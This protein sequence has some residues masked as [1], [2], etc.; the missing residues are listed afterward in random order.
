MKKNII[1]EGSRG[2]F[3]PLLFETEFKNILSFG[4]KFEYEFTV[5]SGNAKGADKMG[6]EMAK[7]YNLPFEVFKPDWI[8][9][10]RSA[11]VIRNVEM[12][13]SADFCIC[14]WDGKSPGTNHM[15]NICK[16]KNIVLKTIRY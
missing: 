5:L 15:R 14:F 2:F 8:K 7:K 13:N 4:K 10:G 3:D 1:I 9:N 16:R 12:A 11:G 6:I